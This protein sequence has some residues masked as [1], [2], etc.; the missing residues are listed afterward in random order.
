MKRIIAAIILLLSCTEYLSVPHHTKAQKLTVDRLLW[1]FNASHTTYLAAAD[2]VIYAASPTGCTDYVPC[3]PPAR[4]FALDEKSGKQKWMIENVGGDSA[5]VIADGRVYQSGGA[6]LFA[7][8]AQTGQVEWKLKPGANGTVMHSPVI[9]KGMI[10]FWEV[11]ALI[12]AGFFGGTL[13]AVDLKTREQK[14]KFS[15]SGGMVSAPVTDD[16]LIYVGSTGGSLVPEKGRLY[17]LDARTGS[18]RWKLGVAGSSLTADGGIVYYAGT[19]GFLYA[20]D[21]RKGRRLWKIKS[22]QGFY[23]TDLVNGLVYLVVPGQKLQAVDSKTG[24]PKWEFKTD[25]EVYSSPIVSRGVVYV[26]SI[27][28]GLYALD[29]KSGHEL[30]SFKMGNAMV[31][32]PLVADGAVYVASHDGYIYAI[33]SLN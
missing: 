1:K 26:G 28:G 30:W 29:A 13:H 19:D 4:L 3:G 24:Q 2:S 18:V 6:S 21:A 15:I 14:W 5:P 20:L 27:D 7:I 32:S 17:A 8:N 33:K 31:S 16:G 23:S 9:A 10:F 22:V 25:R 11:Q 12:P